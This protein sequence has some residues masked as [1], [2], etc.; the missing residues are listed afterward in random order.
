MLANKLCPLRPIRLLS[1]SCVLKRKAG[2][3]SGGRRPI[4]D[5]GLAGLTKLTI[6][7][8]DIHHA[9]PMEPINYEK[10]E[11]KDVPYPKQITAYLDKHVIGQEMA[12]KTLAVGIY[13]HYKRLEHNDEIR[14]ERELSQLGGLS[15]KGIIIGSKNTSKD[16]D[17]L[18]DMLDESK[19]PQ[20][21]DKSNI[22]LVGPSGVGKTYITQRL[23]AILD[24][25][26]AYCDCT[27]LTQAGYVGDDADTVIQ[28]L[29]Q[30]A[31]GDVER[32]MRGIV[33]LDEFDKISS[34]VD[35]IHSANGFRDVSG[36]GVQ[37]ALL[38]IVEGS[39]VRV[40]NPYTQ[41]AKIEIDTS[42]I[43]FVASGAFNQLDRMVGKRMNKR[44]VG[45][46]ADVTN[47]DED[48]LGDD[49]VAVAR[50][51]DELLMKV[52]P[53][54]LVTF[55]MIPELVGRF[56]VVVPFQSLDQQ[57]LVRVLKEPPNSLIN[58]VTRQFH[59]DNIKLKFTDG[60]LSA[61]AQEAVQRKTGARALRA[62]IERVLLDA[63][64]EGPGSEV[65]EV[66]ITEEGIKNGGFCG[67]TKKA[68]KN[69]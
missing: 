34:S 32:A 30:N 5:F 22:V 9:R 2:R 51:R 16:A 60:A 8:Q 25:P 47:H 50:K 66:I 7:K 40:K 20:F 23:A 15:K 54:D 52:E 44:S 12:K 27:V 35:P 38:K 68:D 45:F 4:S 3:K 36:R 11:R 41:G 55:G 17:T 1:T 14:L 53:S 37:Q 21:L 18:N 63:K 57:Q 56:P 49:E 6:P 43:L 61:I 28:K 26:F 19:N 64:Y 58:Q 62:I 13:Q 59:M 10:Y 48:L 67:V 65:T 24:V 69:T 46:G 39:V 33:F 29:L 42:D 31:D